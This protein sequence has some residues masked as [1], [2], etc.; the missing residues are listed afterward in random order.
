MIGTIL[1]PS[2]LWKNFKI[3]EVNASIIKQNKKG[4]LITTKLNIEGRAVKDGT[5]N[6]YFALLQETA[7]RIFLTVYC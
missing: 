5:V 1:T 2:A 4:G 6:I 3:E 7:V